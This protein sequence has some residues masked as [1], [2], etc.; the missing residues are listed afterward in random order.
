L[1]NSFSLDIHLSNRSKPPWH[2]LGGVIF[3][4]RRELKV[5]PIVAKFVS[6]EFSGRKVFVTCTKSIG[7]AR[8]EP[9]NGDN[10]RNLRSNKNRGIGDR[11]LG[12]RYLVIFPPFPL[13][14]LASTR[15]R[16]RRPL[17]NNHVSHRERSPRY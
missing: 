13:F 16:R 8:V 5:S 14:Q 15:S 12:F 17:K 6:K 3:N 7:Q 10:Y 2:P 11:N 9:V 4:V 1:L